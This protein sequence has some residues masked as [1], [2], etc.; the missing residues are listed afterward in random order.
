MNNLGRLSR[1]VDRTA[2]GFLARRPAREDLRSSAAE[3][4]VPLPA[5]GYLLTERRLRDMLAP[6]HSRNYPPPRQQQG[7]GAD[8]SPSSFRFSARPARLSKAGKSTTFLDMTG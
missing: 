6:P 3:A 8:E 7:T 5:Y 1:A 4:A 2:A